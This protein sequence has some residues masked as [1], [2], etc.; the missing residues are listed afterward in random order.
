MKE[1]IILFLKGII[2]GIGKVIPGVSGSVLALSLGVYEKGVYA[3]SHF[4]ENVK[5]NSWFLFRS[6]L[7]ILVSITI[8]STIILSLLNTYYFSIMLLFCG[9]IIGT[10]PNLQKGIHWRNVKNLTLFF[11]SLLLGLSFCL[12]S[13]SSEYTY[14][15]GFSSFLF[16]L[17]TGFVEAAT[18][19]VPGISGTAI[20][21]LLGVYPL[22]LNTFS[23]LFSFHFLFYNIEILLPFGLGILLATLLVTKS[24]YYFLSKDEEKTYACICGFSLS[25]LFLL[26][27][28]AFTQSQSFPQ[29]SFLLCI[30]GFFLSYYLEKKSQK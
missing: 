22:V 10:F 11:L 18:M 21:M 15:P 24:M 13:F 4:T 7:G 8:G 27:Q 5:E 26:I 6:G 2:I 23:H 19:I 29:F 9:L 12:I 28:K 20:L 3:L 30:I 17:L 14:E 25:S 1:T 16:L